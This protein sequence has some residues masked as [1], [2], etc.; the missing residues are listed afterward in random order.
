ME[1]GRIVRTT[2]FVQLDVDKLRYFVGKRSVRYFKMG[3]VRNPGNGKYEPGWVETDPPDKMLKTILAPEH[4]AF[5]QV[6]GIITAPTLRNDG[7]V[8]DQQ[9]YDK[10]TQLHAYW[11][12]KLMETWQ[13][14]PEQPTED[15][16]RAALQ[17]FID[18]LKEVAFVSDLDKSV[19]LAAI[20]SGV[21]RGAFRFCPLVLFLASVAGTGKSYLADIASN[22][23]NGRDCPVITS[24]KDEP[25]MEKRLASI[26]LEGSPIIS[27]DNLSFD[28]SSDLLNQ[29]C[30][31]D[32]IKPR[33]LGKS[34]TP[35]CEWRGVVFA[36]GNNVALVGDLTRRGL[37]C[38]LYRD[39]DQPE[40]YDYKR[41]PITDIRNNRGLYLRAAMIIAKAYLALPKDKM[42]K[43]SRFGGFEEWS[44]FVREPLIWLGLPDPV[45][46]QEQ[47]RKDDPKRS[48]ARELIALWKESLG[49]SETY[50]VRNIIDAANA[51]KL[52]KN[53]K[54]ETENDQYG[55]PKW[56]WRNPELQT[57][58]LE[59]CGQGGKID[60]N[61]LGKWLRS[62]KRQRHDGYRITPVVID[63]AHGNKWKLVTSGSEAN[64][65]PSLKA[66]PSP[67][68]DQY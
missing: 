64:P 54:G 19:A 35:D 65:S 52:I 46:S 22:I 20:L 57:L 9:G 62:L 28:L 37:I 21:L 61:K 10:D 14:I 39:M 43:C 60:S 30:T 67:E 55:K 34:R 16:A 31:Q 4:W 47:A 2:R 6:R 11:H 1:D 23:A 33:I 17:V 13:P 32:I 50:R 66:N 63:D 24:S 5:R 36:T 58:L 45:K 26:V 27:L 53:Q 3:R 12:D 29:M 56:E 59:Q 48:A 8:I 49:T 42:V 68:N 40:E 18:L 51:T 38:N 44:R 25:E 7:S 15:E 41:N